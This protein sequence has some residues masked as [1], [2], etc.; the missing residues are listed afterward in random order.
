[1]G[2][3]GSEGPAGSAG[4]L[5]FDSVDFAF[6]GPVVSFWSVDSAEVSEVGVGGERHVFEA[7]EGLFFV[8]GPVGEVGDAVDGFVVWIAVE[9]IY[10]SEGILE[11]TLSE[12]V[13]FF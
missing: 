4:A 9:S 11:D 13:F 1:M 10:F 6:A 3:V 5:V 8:V 7:E 2:G 12:L